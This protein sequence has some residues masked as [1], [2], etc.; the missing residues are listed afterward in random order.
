MNVFCGT[1]TETDAKRVHSA[2]I[3]SQKGIVQKFLRE[4]IIMTLVINLCLRINMKLFANS[5]YPQYRAR[6]KKTLLNAG[7]EAGFKFPSFLLL[8][9]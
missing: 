7:F 4:L 6:K 1:H 3:V 2:R 5:F 9:N 8:V